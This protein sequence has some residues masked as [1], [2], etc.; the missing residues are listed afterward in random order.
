MDRALVWNRAA[1]VCFADRE[2]PIV[3]LARR[4][5]LAD[6][7]GGSDDSLPGVPGE[8]TIDLFLTA[9]ELIAAGRSDLAIGP[10]EKLVNRDPTH[11]GGQFALAYCRHKMGDKGP[12]LERYLVAHA[13]DPTD[14]RPPYNRGIILYSQAVRAAADEFTV[15]LKCDPRYAVASPSGDGEDVDPAGGLPGRRGGPDTSPEERSFADSVPLAAGPDLRQA[16]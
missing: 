10:L 15:A 6:G 13:L 5:R 14:P 11:F 12:A 3:L 7:S 16:K 8:S 4:Q 1:T 9:A 2:E